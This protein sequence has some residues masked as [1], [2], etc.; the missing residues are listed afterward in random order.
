MNKFNSI[1]IVRVCSL[2][3]LLASQ[4]RVPQLQVDGGRE[5][6]LPRA[7]ARLRPPGLPGVGGHLDA[8][9]G[10]FRQAEAHQQRTGRPGTRKRHSE[11]YTSVTAKK[12]KKKKISIWLSTCDFK[13]SLLGTTKDDF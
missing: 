10:Q 11:S 1:W 6:R 3:L 13:V 4:V 2:T 12:G 7:A 8:A 5:R 9:G